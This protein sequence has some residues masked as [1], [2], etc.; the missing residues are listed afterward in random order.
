MKFRPGKK[1]GHSP[2]F[3]IPHNFLKLTFKEVVLRADSRAGGAV[4]R[5]RS[6][7]KA[8]FQDHAVASALRAT[9]IF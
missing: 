9:D 5:F 2:A 4:W 3:C 1:Y 7:V 6:A 8:D